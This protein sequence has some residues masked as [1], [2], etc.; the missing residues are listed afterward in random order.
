[1]SNRKVRIKTKT[2]GSRVIIKARTVKSSVSPANHKYLPASYQRNMNCED[3]FACLRN[4]RIDLL[5]TLSGYFLKLPVD[6]NLMRALSSGSCHTASS[7][8]IDVLCHLSILI[9]L[10]RGENNRWNSKI[11]LPTLPGNQAKSGLACDNFVCL[12][13]T[14]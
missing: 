10:Y 6:K 4:R 11:N 8:S 3:L 9:Y 13:K 14:G 1:M 5:L 7:G 2:P 12:W